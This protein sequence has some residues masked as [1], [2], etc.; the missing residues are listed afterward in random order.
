[1]ALTATK[2]QLLFGKGGLSQ[3]IVA[4][5]GSPGDFANSVADIFVRQDAKVL[6]LIDLAPLKGVELLTG[7]PLKPWR[8]IEA[9]EVG[10]TK[11]SLRVAVHIHGMDITFDHAIMHQSINIIGRFPFTG[12]N[13]IS[14]EK[15][16]ALVQKADDT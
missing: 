2:E 1:M 10:C 14:M 9:Q 16:I 5:R 13:D 15:E 6:I 3:P 4:R 11:D 12:V 7:K 8:E